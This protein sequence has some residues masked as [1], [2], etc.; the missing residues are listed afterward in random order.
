M[1]LRTYRCGAPLMPRT[2]RPIRR[3][4]P[5]SSW[6]RGTTRYAHPTRA[7]PSSRA[8]SSLHQASVRPS[9][10]CQCSPNAEASS[11]STS[12]FV[13]KRPPRHWFGIG[14]AR[15]ELRDFT[16]ASCAACVMPVTSVSLATCRW[17]VPLETVGDLGCAGGEMEPTGSG[18][19]VAG[20]ERVAR[21]GE[22]R[23][24]PS[25]RREPIVVR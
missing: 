2:S 23:R 17:P 8:R 21:P 18:S 24:L 6:G 10:R 11:S 12:A 7:N 19:L 15:R 25:S 20:S 1:N 9:D 14:P 5:A 16:R 3:G 22:S 4:V 13:S